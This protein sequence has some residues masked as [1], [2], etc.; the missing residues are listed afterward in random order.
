MRLLEERGIYSAGVISCYDIEMIAGRIYLLASSHT[1]TCL[2][3][4]ADLGNVVPILIPRSSH[5][6]AI[7]VGSTNVLTDHASQAAGLS[8]HPCL[9]KQSTYKGK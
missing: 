4:P 1:Q 2:S 8:I 3:T 9:A 6:P 7:R 5:L